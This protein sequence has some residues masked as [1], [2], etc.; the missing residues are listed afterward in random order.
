MATW[1]SL[2]VTPSID[3]VYL[4]CLKLSVTC[5]T[6][7]L[8]KGKSE[9]TSAAQVGRIL[10]VVKSLDMLQESQEFPAIHEAAAAFLEG[11]ETTD[12]TRNQI[13]PQPVKINL[14]KSRASFENVE[15]FPVGDSQLSSVSDTADGWK[16]VVQLEEVECIL[17]DAIINLSFVF[18]E[19]EVNSHC[20]DDCRGMF[21]F[22]VLKYRRARN[23]SVSVVPKQACP[24]FGAQLPG[25]SEY[26]SIDHSQMIFNS[27]RQIA[28]AMQRLL[29][30]IAQSQGD[31][32]HRN[33]KL[34][35]PTCSWFYIKNHFGQRGIKIHDV[36][37]NQPRPILGWGLTYRSHREYCDMEILR[38]DTCAKI[39]AFREVFG[40]T[41]GYGVRKKRPRYCDGESLIN[42]NDVLN[43]VFL[44]TSPG[45]DGEIYEL[46]EHSLPAFQRFGVM[47]DGIDLGYSK[48]DGILQ[49]TLRYRKLV[50][51]NEMVPYLASVGV[52]LREA[53]A[54]NDNGI[55]TSTSNMVNP[56]TT[57]M[58]FPE[59][60]F[61]DDGY[62]MQV[63]SVGPNSI[64]ARRTYKLLA[65][66]RSMGVCGFHNDV[67]YTDLADIW[68]RIQ[69]RLR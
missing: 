64:R 63:T 4:P 3:S 67:E 31:F 25:F 55:T 26:W 56:T 54:G 12:V 37:F 50:V 57:A 28:H 51:T 32:A 16:H 42:I 45:D 62:L 9:P 20:H 58:I 19:E 24:T 36:G 13:P 2:I 17:A 30:R 29:C 11:H 68:N 14:F 15:E 49:I 1:D 27:I 33:M 44:P 23:G 34:H 52:G 7:V 41:S 47:E 18:L 35:L 46:E 8:Y 59:M 66:N 21:N 22:F 69:E 6:F 40:Y 48:L 5:G 53:S 10:E 38:F 65:G 43:V 61:V 60:E 39:V